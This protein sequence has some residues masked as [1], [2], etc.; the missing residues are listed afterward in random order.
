M[1]R[2]CDNRPRLFRVNA[3]AALPLLSLLACTRLTPEDEARLS[4]LK[5]RFGGVYS[6][7]AS[8]VYLIARAKDSDADGW[9]HWLE[10]YKLFWL[11]GKIPRSNT[12]LVYLNVYD[13]MDVWQGQLYW[14]PIANQIAFGHER[15]HY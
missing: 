8:D 7:S 10:M 4:A 5:A 3:L 12:S 9:D 6:L 13:A 1:T 14:D 15:E 11:D 2:T